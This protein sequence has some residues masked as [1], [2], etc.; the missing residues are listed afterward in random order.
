MS[1]RDN[2]ESYEVFAGRLHWLAALLVGS[3]VGIVWLMYVL[4]KTWLGPPPEAPRGA[5]IPTPRLQPN[6]HIDLAHERSREQALLERYQWVD[7]QAGI[8]RIP[9]ERAMQLLAGSAHGPATPS[10]PPASAAPLA[11]P[12]PAA[13]SQPSASSIPVKPTSQGSQVAL[14]PPKDLYRRA[15]VDQ[16]LGVQVPLRLLFRDSDGRAITLQAL[17]HGKPTL[18]ALGYYRCPNLCD[19]TL[20]GMGRA[21]AAMPLRVGRDYQV[22]FVSID[23]GE[24]PRD[25]HATAAMLEHDVPAGQP[26]RW[27]LL[28]GTQSAIRGLSEATGFRSFRDDRIGQYAHAAGVVVLTGQGLI[29]QYFF[30][31]SYSPRALRLALV[32]ASGGHLGSILDQLVLLCCAYDP[33]TGRYSLLIGKIMQALGIVFVLGAGALWWTLHRGRRA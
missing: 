8:A 33:S 4:S 12:A 20:H 6:P 30:G 24:T 13:Q 1:Q 32:N 26:D 19:M 14:P 21:A 28:T 11:P 23:P 18:L 5:A 16:H 15:G 25:A 2:H 7:R 22:A 10:G 3:L 31:V 9:I 17:T 29:A 27:H